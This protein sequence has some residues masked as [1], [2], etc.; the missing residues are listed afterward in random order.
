[1][2]FNIPF[3]C[4]WIYLE[5][6][7]GT[8]NPLSEGAVFKQIN[9]DFR[10]IMKEIAGDPR[11][12]SLVKIHGITNIIDSLENQLNRCQSALTDFINVRSTF[13]DSIRAILKIILE[14]FV[15]HNNFNFEL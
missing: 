8:E 7:F 5:P 2:H 13:I 11:V 9:K 3:F 12:L 14:I 6:I 10:Y 4:R 15:F 1:M